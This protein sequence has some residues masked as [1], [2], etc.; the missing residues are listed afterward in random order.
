MAAAGVLQRT[1]AAFEHA[2]VSSG[3]VQQM[4]R[5][6]LAAAFNWEQT[7]EVRAAQPSFVRAPALV[8]L[9]PPGVGKGTYS[10]RVAEHL[11][12]PHISAG[13][14]AREEMRNG[15]ARGQQMTA[16]VNSGDLLP[17]S[18]ILDVL[19]ERIAS[20]QEAGEPGVLLDGFPRTRAQAEA[21]THTADVQLAVNLHVRE[22]ILIAKCLGRRI[23]GHC[24]ANYNVANIHI[25]ESGSQPAINMP[26]LSPPPQCEKHMQMR[27]DD[28]LEIIKKRLEVYNSAA[29]PVEDF[30]RE[31]GVL[32]D[33]DIWGGIPE[34][35]PRLLKALEPHIHDVSDNSPKRATVG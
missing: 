12:L 9:G 2:A 3:Q 11:G 32:L 16:M 21:L 5:G 30:F 35:L 10:K 28:T 8:F 7:S 15:S 1:K 20:G 27:S 13:D 33:F 24:G 31:R 19:N 14:L 23:C 34:T 29:K 6:P 4:L 18:M 26:P 22:E 17:D 25:P